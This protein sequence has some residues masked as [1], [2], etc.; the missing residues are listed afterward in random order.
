MRGKTPKRKIT[1][2][3]KYGSP[4]VAKFVNYVMR[5]GMKSVARGIVYDSFSAIE[6]QTKKDPRETFDAALRNVTPEVEVRS[7]RVGGANYQIPTPVT[8]ERKQALAFRWLLTAA[9]LRKGQPMWK[10]LAAELTDAANKQG[11]AFKKR[12]DVYR[13]AEANRAFAH[14]ARY[15]KRR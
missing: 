12:E 10:R 11:A 14:F 6:E 4:T 2:D 9:R 13:M 15:G 5:K 7:R 1:P 8:P 3:P